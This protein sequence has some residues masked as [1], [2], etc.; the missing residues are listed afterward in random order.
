MIPSSGP[1]GARFMSL[2]CL[3]LLGPIPASASDFGVTGLLDVPTARMSV[4]GTLTTSIA[5]QDTVDIYALTYQALPWVEVSVVAEQTA[6]S[7]KTQNAD[8]A[9]RMG[10]GRLG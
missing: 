7:P 10:R 3:V 4:D 8:I 5:Q 1:F 2:V 6:A 9:L